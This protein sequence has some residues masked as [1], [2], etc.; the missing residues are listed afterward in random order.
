MKKIL[1]SA[2]MLLPLCA[3]MSTL[4]IG[5]DRATDTNEYSIEM[6]NEDWLYEKIPSSAT[7]GETVTV[8]IRSATDLGYIFTVNG[9][10]IEQDDVESN[11]YWQF[12]FTMPDEDVIIDFKTYDGFLPDIAYG[13]L[14]ET[15][16]MQYPDAEYVSVREYYGEYDGNVL[17]AMIDAGDVTANEW[18]EEVAG[19][20]FQYGDGNRVTVLCNGKFYTLPE[21]YKKELLTE[22]SVREIFSKYS[23]IHDGA[24]I[25]VKK[26]SEK[27]VFLKKAEEIR[28][29]AN[30]RFENAITQ[31]DLNAESGTVREKWDALLSEVQEYL[32]Q[33]LSESE[34]KELQD[35]E[36]E[37][38]IAK[39]KAINDAAEE[40]KGGSGE[41]MARNMA[42]TGCMEERFN[43]LISLLD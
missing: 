27:D 7:V 28:E 24:Y 17:A 33:E 29:Y 6:K 2:F 14:I 22:E 19:C 23:A 1:L 36:A 15:Y 35:S 38:L 26:P 32:K 8:K 12:S 3:F 40:W 41:P 5:C 39:E 20:I 42:A 16:W 13:T 21:A 43:Y 31:Y 30:D 18:S 9:E 34:Y 25:E 10:Q 37:W 11:E 4:F